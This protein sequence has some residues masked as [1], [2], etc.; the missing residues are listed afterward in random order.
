M[1]SASKSA[2]NPFSLGPRNCIGRNLAYLE[3][4]LVLTHLLWTFDLEQ[5]A[6][7]GPEEVERWETQK[8]WI[9]WDKAPL[10]VRLKL[11]DT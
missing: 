4:R 10:I 7:Q 3:M 2:F 11:R 1:N 6:V 8:N 9:L 5:P